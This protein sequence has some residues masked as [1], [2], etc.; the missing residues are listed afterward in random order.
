VTKYYPLRSALDQSGFFNKVKHKVAGESMTLNFLEVKKL[1]LEY[2]DP[3][4]HFA[5]ACAAESCPPLASGAYFP[6]QLKKQLTERT[7][8]SIN[9]KEWLRVKPS[10]KKVQISKIFD[11]YKKDFGMSGIST[12]EFINKYRKIKIPENYMIEYYEYNW[13]LNEG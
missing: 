6:D 9:D 5:L 4:I 2:E 3:L 13:G 11:W 12:L 8:L 1:V 10:Q 7:R